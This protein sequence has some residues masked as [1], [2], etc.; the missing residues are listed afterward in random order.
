MTVNFAGRLFSALNHNPNSMWC[1]KVSLRCC[2]SN[3]QPMNRSLFESTEDM[4]HMNALSHEHRQAMHF[5]I[6]SK[7]LVHRQNF[8]SLPFSCRF[9]V[10]INWSLMSF[11]SRDSMEAWRT[12]NCKD[13][14]R[15]QFIFNNFSLIHMGNIPFFGN[16]S[17]FFFS[18][19]NVCVCICAFDWG[20]RSKPCD[21]VNV[22]C[23][24]FVYFGS[25][26]SFSTFCHR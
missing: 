24:D 11:Y 3:L 22:T 7:C 16:F 1:R 9:P 23:H 13:N 20:K 5:S 18:P 21:V 26:L 10:P 25:F 19:P 15:F 6:E 17:V 8:Y 2:Q 12:A 4:W 14:T